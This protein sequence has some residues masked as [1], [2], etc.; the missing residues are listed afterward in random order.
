M[1]A[2]EVSKTVNSYMRH[3]MARSEKPKIVKKK[4]EQRELTQEEIDFMRYVDAGEN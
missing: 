2:S 1:R 4:V 3:G